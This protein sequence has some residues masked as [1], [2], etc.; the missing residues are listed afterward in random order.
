M[1]LM[2]YL[3]E[4][5]LV[6]T[7]QVVEALVEQ[8]RSLPSSLEIV[9]DLNLLSKEAIFDV[10]AE[11]QISGTDFQCSA[12]KLGFWSEDIRDRI[13]LELVKRRLP[14]VQ[15]LVQR[16]YL[17]L[18]NLSPALNDY[19]ER[20]G[21]VSPS[22]QGKVV[23]ETSPLAIQV[24]PVGRPLLK[25]DSFLI[26]EYADAFDTKFVLSMKSLLSL[27]HNEAK[28]GKAMASAFKLGLMESVV[29]RAA[30]SF[31][32]AVESESI[33]DSLVK[34]FDQESNRLGSVEKVSLLE[35]LEAGL[36]LLNL[37]CQSLKR[38]CC[39]FDVAKD[40]EW[41]EKRERFWKIS[42][43]VQVAKPERAA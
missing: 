4:Q 3:I 5:K 43:H 2:Q 8:L 39:E 16:G 26:S 17:S 28:D 20:A 14:L 18:Q 36:A 22:A 29:I 41:L 19:V 12:K 24:T 40:S 6:K 25:L 23:V 35:I 30:A 42:N 15:I 38:D 32:G 13:H 10:L 27:L 9:F 11:Q 21:Q 1:L 37:H 7:E 31:L 34:I 33:A